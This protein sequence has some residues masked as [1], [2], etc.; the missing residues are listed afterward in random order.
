MPLFRTGLF[1]TDW[2]GKAYRSKGAA[3]TFLKRSG[4]YRGKSDAVHS[5]SM[6]LFEE[7][8]HSATAVHWQGGSVFFDM[9]VLIEAPSA[10]RARHA[11]NMLVASLTT[12]DGS[13]AAVPEPFQVEPHVLSAPGRK[14][15]ILSRDGLLAA[16]SMANRASRRYSLSYAL[17]KLALSY[18]SSSLHIMDVHPRYAPRRFSVRQD[19]MLH[20]Y[21]A[22]AITL[23]YSAIEE[24]GFEIKSSHK[25][26]SKIDGLW[27]PVVKADLEQRLQRGGISLDD[28]F[29]WTLRGPKTRVEKAKP[30]LSNGKPSWSG[31]N[32]RDRDMEVVESLLL[33]SWL[34][35]R[36]SAHRFSNVA[37]SLTEYD[38]FN[39]Q[40]LA[41]RLL[42]E[43]LGLWRADT[44]RQIKGKRAT[45]Q[46]SPHWR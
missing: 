42:L 15:W 5:H 19:P 45:Q 38:A 3:W 7:R 13:T 1:S 6:K 22:N 10:M 2:P 21:L 46:Q 41:R 40:S 4:V 30:P 24:M 20:V 36:V 17:H 27:N 25:E 23:A 33:A 43:T 44:P 18:E 16:C 34:R 37:R 9:E 32:I 31:G 8:G 29:V 11:V 14:N 12:L 28:S 35:S 26:P 39:V